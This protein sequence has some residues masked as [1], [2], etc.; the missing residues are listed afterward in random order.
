MSFLPESYD[1]A[2]QVDLANVFDVIYEWSLGIAALGTARIGFKTG[3]YPVY[4][5]DRSLSY[6][7]SSRLIYSAFMDSVYTGGTV[8]TPLN[9]NHEYP[10]ASTVSVVIDPTVSQQGTLYLGPRATYASGSGSS[11]LGN[12]TPVIKPTLL[13]A[14]TYHIF[15]I[16]NPSTKADF[17]QWGCSFFED[18]T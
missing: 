14:N 6:T 1:I 4:I 3:K 16:Q 2:H 9:A 13:K 8:V 11:R 7:G 5:F 12:D 15:V 18:I 10:R 17:V